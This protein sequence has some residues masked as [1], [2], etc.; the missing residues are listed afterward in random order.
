VARF[1]VGLT[2]GIV[3]EHLTIEAMR[4]RQQALLDEAGYEVLTNASD[5]ARRLHRRLMR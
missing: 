3:E 5:E 2:P 4:D 1:F